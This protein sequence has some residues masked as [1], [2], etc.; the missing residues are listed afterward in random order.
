MKLRTLIAAL[1][2]LTAY[3]LLAPNLLSAPDKRKIAA[4]KQQLRDRAVAQASHGDVPTEFPENNDLCLLCH[5]NLKR[6]EIVEK[7]SGEGILCAHCHGISY[8]H[9]DDE[10]SHTRPDYVFGRGQVAPLCQKCHVGGCEK[11][12]KMAAFLAKWKYKTRPNGRVILK[13]AVCTDCHGT[14]VMVGAPMVGDQDEKDDD[15]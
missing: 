1:L 3:C 13:G 12:E 5:S 7:H 11:P 10:T 2:A 15:D 14:H 6:D 4:A 8:E 9:M